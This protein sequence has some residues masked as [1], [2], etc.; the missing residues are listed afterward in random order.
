MIF[1]L[2]RFIAATRCQLY[3][4]FIDF[5]I[6][7]HAVLGHESS[8]HYSLIL[9]PFGHVKKKN[10]T[11]ILIVCLA[12]L[13]QHKQ[14]KW[15]RKWLVNVQWKCFFLDDIKIT[16]CKMCWENRQ[17]TER[18]KRRIAIRNYKQHVTRV[19]VTWNG[20]SGEI[21]IRKIGVCV[22]VRANCSSFLS[23]SIGSAQQNERILADAKQP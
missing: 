23:I 8:H 18:E 3:V 9:Q 17:I 10:R 21:I 7:A 5:S 22:C 19:A 11:Y 14:K 4:Y 1:F 12:V 13:N 15:E 6:S 2:R 16:V 20:A